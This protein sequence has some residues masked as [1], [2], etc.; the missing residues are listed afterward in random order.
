MLLSNGGLNWKAA[1]AQ[2][3]QSRVLRN[4][5][6]RSRL[7]LLLGLTGIVML[8]YRSLR[9]APPGPQK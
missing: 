1:R 7:L 2:M 4:N 5:M 9:A 8:L 3:P 6:T